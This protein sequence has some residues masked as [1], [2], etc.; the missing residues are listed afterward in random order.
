MT[1]NEREEIV[2]D[3]ASHL[4]SNI[5]Q[6]GLMAVAIDRISD[7][8][9]QKTDEEIIDMA[10]SCLIAVSEKT[11]ANRNKAKPKGF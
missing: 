8:L 5:S 1:E 6:A 7:L 11:K 10:P 3:I 2:Y 4:L 9:L